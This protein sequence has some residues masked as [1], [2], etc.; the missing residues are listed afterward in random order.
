MV[1]RNNYRKLKR[2]V[3][4]KDVKLVCVQYPLRLVEGL[5]LMFDSAQGVV[6]VDNKEV[7]KEALKNGSYEDYFEDRF[8]GDF[9]HCTGKGNYILAENV[10]KS[11][12]KYSLTNKFLS[13]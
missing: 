3:L 1:T 6:F 8:A 12:L 13:H 10:A 9:G 5:K 4:G 2:I 11:I 7:F